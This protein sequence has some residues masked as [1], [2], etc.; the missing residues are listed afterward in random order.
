MS[1]HNNS[2]AVNVQ[3]SNSSSFSSG[4]PCMDKEG[5]TNVWAISAV[6]APPDKMQAEEGSSTRADSPQ[7]VDASSILPD[8]EEGALIRSQLFIPLPLAA[9]SLKPESDRRVRDSTASTAHLEHRSFSSM[10]DNTTPPRMCTY[11]GDAAAATRVADPEVSVMLKS[12]PFDDIQASR[13]PVVSVAATAQASRTTS[14][15]RPTVSLNLRKMGAS[16]RSLPAEFVVVNADKA[17]TAHKLLTSLSAATIAQ[18]RLVKFKVTQRIYRVYYDKW[19]SKF[20][21]RP[22]AQSPLRFSESTQTQALLSRS[23]S[24]GTDFSDIDSFHASR[25]TSPAGDSPLT[26]AAAGAP[27]QGVQ[28][29]CSP[30][31]TASLSPPREGEESETRSAVTWSPAPGFRLQTFAS[32]SLSPLSPSFQH[33]THNAFIP[34][35]APPTDR[36]AVRTNPAKLVDFGHHSE[37][38]QRKKRHPALTPAVKLPV[39]TP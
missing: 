35:P 14:P 29:F 38:P 22:P 13:S 15:A 2:L 10:Q 36:I 31:A 19:W 30:K 25:S 16:G 21:Q 17:C 37:A 4:L 27:P 18:Y 9:S 32:A 20:L 24:A 39:V 26:H 23:V 1:H 7:P 3:F 34:P 28:L 12:E 11:F 8:G 5:G 6:E 33:R